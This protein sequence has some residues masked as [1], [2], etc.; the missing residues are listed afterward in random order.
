[1]ERNRKMLVAALAT[2]QPYKC[3]SSP[4]KAP[5]GR[6]VKA[7]SRKKMPI[8]RRPWTNRG[9]NRLDKAWYWVRAMSKAWQKRRTG[10]RSSNMLTGCGSTKSCHC[11]QRFSSATAWRWIVCSSCQRDSNWA[12]ISFNCTPEPPL[13]ASAMVVASHWAFCISC[14]AATFSFSKRSATSWRASSY[15]RWAA[16]NSPSKRATASLRKRRLLGLDC[17][18]LY[19]VAGSQRLLR[20]LAGLF[21]R[22]V[23]GLKARGDG[24]F[25]R[26]SLGRQPAQIGEDPLRPVGRKGPLVA[27]GRLTSAGRPLRIAGRG[28]RVAN[29]ILRR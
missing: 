15:S 22:L 24:L 3:C 18:F 8:G 5:A 11:P 17:R 10:C 16:A 28:D 29:G 12:W 25:H 27:A 6:V 13:A 7:H 26:H 2:T 23:A 9:M 4:K 19:L 20:L 1:M 14:S 21:R